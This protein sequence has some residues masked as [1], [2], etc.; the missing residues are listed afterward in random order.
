LTGF[1]RLHRS[2]IR[3][4]RDLPDECRAAGAV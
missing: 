3:V 4:G 1:S 2:P